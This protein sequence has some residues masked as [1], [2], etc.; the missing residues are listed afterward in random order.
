MR[1]RRSNGTWFPTLGSAAAVGDDTIRQ[2]RSFAVLDCVYTG[3]PT[4]AVAPLTFDNPQDQDVTA[5]VDQTLSEIVGS[6]YLLKRILGTIIVSAAHNEFNTSQDT[7]PDPLIECGVGIFVARAGDTDTSSLLPIGLQ[8]NAGQSIPDYNSYSVLSSDAIREPW[9]F[10]RTWLLAPASLAY[11][12]MYNQ[13][14]SVTPAFSSSSAGAGGFMEQMPF[15]NIQ[16]GMAGTLKTGPWVDVKSR[17]RVRQDD[18]LWLSISC[19]SAQWVIPSYAP[20]A[21][22]IS[23]SRVFFGWDLRLFGALRKARNS[24]NF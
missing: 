6:E 19:R 24:G 1:R 21:T 11:N 7:I 8:S 9:M 17:R 4:T 12:R 23:D 13:Q 15:N 3:E 18:R 22:D 20:N 2:N 14:L 16:N 5:Q 10:R